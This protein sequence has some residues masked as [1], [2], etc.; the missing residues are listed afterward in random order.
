MYLTNQAVRG[1]VEHNLKEENSPVNLFHAGCKIFARNRK[2]HNSVQLSIKR[3]NRLMPLIGESRTVEVTP[4]DLRKMVGLAEP[5]RAGHASLDIQEL[6]QK[7]A[8]RLKEISAVGPVK[9]TCLS[10]IEGQLVLLGHLGNVKI[11]LEFD[12]TTLYHT[13]LMLGDAKM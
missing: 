8:E 5:D 10:P 1:V 12:K 4:E 11:V 7:T 2:E 3:E 6:D 9:V 13:K